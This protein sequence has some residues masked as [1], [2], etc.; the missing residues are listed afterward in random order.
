[1][2]PHELALA[3]GVASI[4]TAHLHAML[5]FQSP[6]L[7]AR[8]WKLPATGHAAIALT[9][10]DGPDPELTPRVL[11]A[12]DAASAQAVFFLIGANVARHPATARAVV[13]RG[14][15]IA[16]HSMTHP[17]AGVWR[18]RRF[19]KREIADA[20]AAIADATGLVTRWFRPP[21]GHRNIRQA[22]AVSALG[23][24]TVGWSC[25]SRDAIDPDPDRVCARVTRR[26]RPRDILLMHDGRDPRRPA[27]PRT[28]ERW[29]PDVLTT[30][31]DR[32]LTP[33][34]LDRAAT[35]LPPPYADA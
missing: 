21:L 22:L 25:R 17:H 13:D 5:S 15:L 14:H 27:D 11:D 20:E 9:F 30:I 6:L 18:G 10:D 16:N 7:G 35:T 29:L 24:S 8:V 3:A 34:R 19:W 31:R 32:G 33:L 26:L 1:M 23:Y 4:A 2:Q 28:I 12:L